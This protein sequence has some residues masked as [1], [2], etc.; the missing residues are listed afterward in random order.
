LTE[1][2]KTHRTKVKEMILDRV[3]R[4]RAVGF[5]E[6]LRTGL[7]GRG[8][9]KIEAREFVK[10]CIN[11]IPDAFVIDHKNTHCSVFELED[12]HKLSQDKLNA[13]ADIWFRM[14]CFDWEFGLIVVSRYGTLSLIPDLQYRFLELLQNE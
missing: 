3:P 13:Y 2:R 6:T 10:E 8:C 7:A 11:I 4:S 12:T 1:K 9:T 5:R 14:D